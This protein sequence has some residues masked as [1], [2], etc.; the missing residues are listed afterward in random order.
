MTTNSQSLAGAPL[1]GFKVLDLTIALA[2]PYGTRLLA[3]LG[4]EVIKVDTRTERN[5]ATELDLTARLQAMYPNAEPGNE[6]WNSG[7]SHTALNRNKHSIALDLGSE[8]GNEQFLELVRSADCVVENFTPKVMPKLGLGHEVLRSVNPKLVYVAMPGFGSEGP[9]SGFP[10]F[11]PT[12]EA[13]S[14]FL[15]LVGYEDGESVPNPMSLADYVGG[16]NAVVGLMAALWAAQETGEGAFVDL[17]Q[18]EAMSSFIGEEFEIATTGES[19][20]E[21]MVGNQQPGSLFS[22]VLPARGYDEW[23]AI[24]V[25]TEIQLRTLLEFAAIQPDQRLSRDGIKRSENR[26]ALV[27]RLASWTSQF[28][29][30][31]L[32]QS[33]QAIGIPAA[34]VQTAPDLLSD[35][36]LHHLEFFLEVEEPDLRTQFTHEGQPWHFDS[37]KGR[38]SRPAP[39]IGSDTA[40]IVGDAQ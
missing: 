34:P 18:V 10:A 35:P 7:G 14:G 32:A 1:E 33:L 16:L 13:A 24:S 36:Q 22:C 26:E 28:G 2:G 17:S 39:R 3:D 20:E 19:L 12:T 40:R 27:S 11:A 25:R 21:S 30:P 15:A 8:V 37:W 23:I 29:K 38:L 6:P 9:R 31:E 4:A 5:Y